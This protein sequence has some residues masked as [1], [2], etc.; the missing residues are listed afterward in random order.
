[1]SIGILNNYSQKSGINSRRYSQGSILQ[2]SAEKSESHDESG[3][4][5]KL[6]YENRV[7]ARQKSVVDQNISY[8]DQ[9]HASRTKAKEVAL[10]KKR[11]QYS[12]KKIS[13]QIIRS[14]NSV[15]ARK[16][17]QAAKREIQRLKRLKGSGEYDE[18]ELQLAIDHAKSMEKVAKKKVVHLEQEEMVERHGKGLSGALEELE[19]EREEKP[20]DESLKDLEDAELDE[21]AGEYS[22][23]M[24]DSELEEINDE[25]AQMMEEYQYEMK[26]EMQELM[27]EL[28]SDRE[29][30]IAQAQESMSQYVEELS[31]EMSEMLEEMDLTE[32]SESLYA[33]DPNMS[34]DDLKM[35]K[36]K[37][38]TK[39]M[40]EIAE[41]DKDYL[42]G[43]ME[44]EKSKAAGGAMPT[45]PVSS[46][47][48]VSS[49]S[50][51]KITPIISMPGA[52]AG[53]NQVAPTVTG[54]FD[55]SV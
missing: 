35:L 23:Q 54:G 47:S 42:K 50:A 18:E 11:V 36:I 25:I 3:A 37:H 16:A 40:K 19:K 14:K 13:S 15:S 52:A 55:V 2:K 10:E 53:G 45:G 20:E 43:I 22:D 24:A 33:P 9:L 6:E 4:L 51:H 28:S 21:L 26:L 1:M 7:A 39:E 30:A 12:F 41:A 27:K 38:R 5:R 17:V 44:H 32:L 31:D 46:P 29:A 48:P 8:A 49:S 34:D